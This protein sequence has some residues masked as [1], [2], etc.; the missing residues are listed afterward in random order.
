MA[1]KSNKLINETSP[2]LLQHAYNPVEWYPWGDEALKRARDEN[3]MIFLSIGY[4][5][6]HWCHVMEH[7][8]FEDPDT[9]RLMNKYFINIKVDREERPD[10]D[11]VYMEALQ[12]MTGQG[13]WPLNVWLTPDKI[14]VFG[15][16]YFPPQDMHGR[17][18]FSTILVRLAEVYEHSPENVR[19]QASKMAEALQQDLYKKITPGIVNRQLLDKVCESYKKNYEPQYGGFSGA[20]KFPMVMGIEFLMRYHHISGNEDAKEMALHSLDQMIMGGI[21]DQIGGGLHRYSTDAEWL[22]PHFEKMLYDNALLL[23]ALCD[24]WQISKKPL[25]RETIYE[26]FAWAKREML[27]DDGG[28]Y[29]ALDA[30]TE[31]EEGKFYVWQEEEINRILDRED[32]EFFKAVYSVTPQGN[33]EGKTI[34]N[35]SKELDEYAVEFNTDAETLKESL[36]RSKA[37]LLKEREKRTRPGLDDKIITSWNAM[38]LKSL[39]KCY[40][41]FG[42]DAFKVTALNNA[43]LMITELWQN[44]TLYRTYKNG[45]SR[46]HGFLD[47]YALLSEA[48][49]YVFEITGDEKYLNIAL[50]L[51]ARL[52]ESFYDEE[53][54]AFYYT[55]ENHEK[56]IVNSRDVFDNVTPS[57]NSAACMA[58]QRLGAIS[59]DHGLQNIASKAIERLGEVMAEHG[60][61]FGYLLQAA[62]NQVEPSREI[63][64]VGKDPLP[65]QKAWANYYDPQ[66]FFIM[67]EDFQNSPHPTLKGK[68]PLG[69]KATAYICRNFECKE[70]VSEPD[71]FQ[72]MLVTL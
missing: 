8:S 29:S 46:Q 68:K 19:Q 69:S 25:Y 48:L 63:I 71:V 59:G 54:D 27:S 11:S 4:S 31:G 72:E 5:S 41:I 30:D 16:T 34:F 15:G 18:D 66:S 49:S 45:I 12:M 40:K 61:V 43:E 33:W 52:Q 57:G 13:G 22:A 51:T 36:E 20:P 28:F 67:G 62:I 24:A 2:Y 3:K 47:D 55:S 44:N 56:L 64:V 53:H 21:Y 1:K 42:D 38:M 23:S 50:S 32:R 70:P 37:I 26:T 65:F 14:P 58:F 9:A 60:T 39:C 17:P 6:C 10:L 7:E 35:R